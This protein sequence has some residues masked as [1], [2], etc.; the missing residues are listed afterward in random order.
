VGQAYAEDSAVNQ[1]NERVLERVRALPG[2][3]AAAAAG[4]IPMGGNYDQRGFH[5]E[6]RVPANTS[7]DPSVERY[8]VTPAYF[9]VMRI[10][11]IRGRLLTDGD[12]AD[13]PPVMVL[14]E[15]TAQQLWRGE[16]PIGHR[17]S[18]GDPKTG[19]WRTVVGIVGDVRHF[20]LDEA[21]TLQMYTPQSQITDSF[22]VL[23]VRTP[24]EPQALM[25]SLRGVLRDLDPTVPVY[26][27]ATLRELI[28]RTVAQRRFVMQL[29]GGFAGLAL[30]LA[31]VGLYGVVSYMVAQRTREVGLRVALGAAPGHI[32]R[33]IL[34][35]GFKT[36]AIGLIVGLVATLIVVRFLET[37]LFGVEPHD[38][39]TLASAAG[40]LTLVAL[41][42]HLI[43]ACRALRI[44]PA[45]ALRQD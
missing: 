34:G 20:S 42:A 35:S 43:P 9:N 44:D 10:P 30:L 12:R 23:T 28:D 19:P 11:L 14:G 40:I 4:Q 31:T 26:E 15:S 39:A 18:I 25:P 45:I 33:L 6:G 2:V 29:L 17:V 38:P 7:E 24:M 36:V 37:L 8:S 32:L 21:P 41:L 22:L 5:I 1:F 16:D 27:V 13:S 3:E